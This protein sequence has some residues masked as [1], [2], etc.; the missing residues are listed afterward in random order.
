MV[1]RSGQ[2]YIP[3]VGQISVAGI[4]Y[5]DL[6]QHLKSEISTIFKNFNVTTSIGRLRSIQL[7]VIGNARYPGT[8][9]ISSLRTLVDAIFASGGPTPQ[10]S[11]RYIQVGR[12]GAIITDF[13][14]YDLLIRGDRSK[15]CRSP[16]G[17]CPPYSSGWSPGR[18]RV[19][20][21]GRLI[22]GAG[23]GDAERLLP[24]ALHGRGS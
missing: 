18:H 19:G 16:A 6:E 9:T 5:G 22:S 8:Y 13:D 17:R 21:V 11:L 24:G 1:D 20:A 4:H 3:Q 2:I 12:D 10:G 14:F 7:I 15:V 23:E